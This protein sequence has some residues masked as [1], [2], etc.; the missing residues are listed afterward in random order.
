MRPGP[1][2]STRLP[3][4]E[5]AAE[6]EPATEA[7]E[8]RPAVAACR[9]GV[10]AGDGPAL[11]AQALPLRAVLGALLAPG[12]KAPASDGSEAEDDTA[13]A[14]AATPWA[15]LTLGEPISAVP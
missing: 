5:P 10:R 9:L 1:G 14:G 6:P 13:T 15:Q 3:G 7:G 8:P 4:G 12:L 11:A 2:L